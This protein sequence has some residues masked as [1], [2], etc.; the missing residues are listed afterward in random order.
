MKP[1]LL[2]MMAAAATAAPRS[3]WDGVY[4]SE[5]AGRGKK[6]YDSQCARCHGDTLGG[7]DDS[8]ALVGE[9]FLKKWNDKALGR[10]V[11][12]TRRT[13]PSDGPGDLSR[14]DTTDMIAYMLSANGF[15]TGKT[16]LDSDA[17]VQKQIMIERKK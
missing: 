7:V 9:A 6:A 16:D 17:S 10:L 5:Q 14:Q 2:L 4:S 3:V 15:P 11:D 8:P 13:M 1:V 12:I